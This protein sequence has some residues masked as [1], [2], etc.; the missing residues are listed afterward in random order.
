MYSMKKVY[1]YL[2]RW[3]KTSGMKRLDGVKQLNSPPLNDCIFVLDGCDGSLPYLEKDKLS[4]SGF[5]F[6]KKKILIMIVSLCFCLTS[7]E[8]LNVTEI[9][10]GSF[11]LAIIPNSLRN[12]I[13]RIMHG[14]KPTR[15]IATAWQFL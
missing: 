13:L 11:N 5:V 8:L 15:G 4:C 9:L 3:C 10:D 7:F 6:K 12:L 1:P 14:M 2:C